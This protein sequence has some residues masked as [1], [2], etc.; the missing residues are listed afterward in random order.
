MLVQPSRAA[1]V[2]EFERARKVGRV[3]NGLRPGTSW[4]NWALAE[5]AAL[6]PVLDPVDAQKCAL[7][8]IGPVWFLA[9]QP[10]GEPPLNPP[11]RRCNVPNGKAILVPIINAEWSAAEGNCPLPGV[12][13]GSSEQALR[14]CAK[15][16]MD[17]VTEIRVS[18]DN[19]PLISLSMYRFQS[20]LFRLTAVM[21]NYA[22]VP[23]GTSNAV[24]DGFYI[25]LK[26]LPK[27]KHTIRFEG[28]IE[29]FPFF[30]F[31]R[32]EVWVGP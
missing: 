25:M 3:L 5:T 26:P 8:Q 17:L 11:L 15:A 9:G 29:S 16:F 23:A 27:G 28:A 22:G 24:A 4:W 13:Q 31:A 18:V 19:K 6:S 21:D 14:A 1:T 2:C 32:Y 10:S 30:A 12:P 7:G 20:P